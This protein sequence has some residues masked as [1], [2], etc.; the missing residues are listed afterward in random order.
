MN[1]IQ[2]HI[3]LKHQVKTL[4]VPLSF[5]VE[6]LKWAYGSK[7][8]K[9]LAI[10]ILLCRYIVSLIPSPLLKLNIIFLTQNP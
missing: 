10:T 1:F 2:V 4:W 8:F 6:G 9:G 3:R 5:V 7:W